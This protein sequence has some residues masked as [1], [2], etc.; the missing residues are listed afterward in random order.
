M[1][2]GCRKCGEVSRKGAGH[3]RVCGAA[4]HFTEIRLLK[5]QAYRRNRAICLRAAIRVTLRR[6]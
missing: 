1:G 5:D 6:C 3:C 2:Y 4:G